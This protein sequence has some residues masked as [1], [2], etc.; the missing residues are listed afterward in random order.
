MHLSL[1]FNDESS[2]QVNIIFSPPWRK[3][4]TISFNPNPLLGLD[5]F[6]HIIKIESQSLLLLPLQAFL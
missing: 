1:Q 5:L 2:N 3:L 6:T 4:Q